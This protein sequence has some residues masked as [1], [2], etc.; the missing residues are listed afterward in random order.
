MTYEAEGFC[1]RNRDVLF[2]DLIEL[3]QSSNNHFVR[4]LFPENT[5]GE[6][7]GKPT[8]LGSKIKVRRIQRIWGFLYIFSFA[9]YRNTTKQAI[10]NTRKL[11]YR[12]SLM[13]RLHLV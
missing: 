13:L 4:S 11:G 2:T 7:K 10:Y 6:R 3:M 9:S 12:N 1:E 8:T 5:Q